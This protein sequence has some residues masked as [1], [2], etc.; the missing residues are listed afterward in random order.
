V[1]L[2][3][4]S[5]YAHEGGGGRVKKLSVAEQTPALR[6]SVDSKEKGKFYFV[7]KEIN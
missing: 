3:E 6:K 5:L 7:V 2:A 4:T 1:Y